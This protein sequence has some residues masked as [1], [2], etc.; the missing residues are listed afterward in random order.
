MREK[1][2]FPRVAI[3][4]S[5]AMAHL[6]AKVVWPNFETSDVVDLSYK[7]I[8][9]KRPGVLKIEAEESLTIELNLGSHPSFK[10][11]VRVA[12][13]NVEMAGL[14]FASLPPEGHQAMSDFLGAQMIG[15][16]LRPVQPD[17]YSAKKDFS[18]W[19]QGAENTHVFLKLNAERRLE[20]AAVEFDG[21][22]VEFVRGQKFRFAGAQSRK[23]L[24]V[25][26]QVDKP[27]LSIKE[28]IASLGV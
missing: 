12:W 16:S 9:S 26:A 5:I 17:L 7:G 13:C 27:E 2:R 20:K 4:E 24:L 25:L 8:A 18:L 21:G 1:R 28:F 15:M 19:L 3:V 10:V 22:S 23:A 14:N 6:S 11:L